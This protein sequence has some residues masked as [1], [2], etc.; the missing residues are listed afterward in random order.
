MGQDLGPFNPQSSAL[1]N[2]PP[3]T[4]NEY[5]RFRGLIVNQ[6]HLIAMSERIEWANSV[7]TEVTER[8][9]GPVPLA[10]VIYF[11]SVYIQPYLKN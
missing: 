4:P 6:Q 11:S 5:I 1:T 10:T 2:R 7:R 8:S 3:A 9:R